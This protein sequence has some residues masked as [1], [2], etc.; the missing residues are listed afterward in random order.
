LYDSIPNTSVRSSGVVSLKAHTED[1]IWVGDATSKHFRSG[2]EKE[3][4]KVR[5]F[6][7]VSFLGT[8]PILKLFVSSELH[9]AVRDAEKGRGK[10]TP[11]AFDAF[12]SHNIGYAMSHALVGSWRV[13]ASGEHAGFDDPYWVGEDCSE[14]ALSD[15]CVSQIKNL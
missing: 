14:D 7:F 13:L 4:V 10:T 12:V 11:E 9:G 1:L 15:Q 5:Q 8:S 6:G 3:I 2:A